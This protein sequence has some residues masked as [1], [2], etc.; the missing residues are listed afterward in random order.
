MNFCKLM[1]PELVGSCSLK[2]AWRVEICSLAGVYT[3]CN[4]ASL[5]A[6]G[7]CRKDLER[8]REGGEY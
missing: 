5:S 3:F 7:N 6:C 2:V 4:T 1:L 8:G